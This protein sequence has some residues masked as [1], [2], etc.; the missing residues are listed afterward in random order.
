MLLWFIFQLVALAV[1]PTAFGVLLIVAACLGGW[2]NAARLS[3]NKDLERGHGG[4]HGGEHGLGDWPAKSISAVLAAM[5]ASSGLIDLRLA[6]VVVM[7]AALGSVAVSWQADRQLAKTLNRA[8]ELVLAWLVVGIPA[9]A[10][11]VLAQ[12]TVS[13]AVVL[14]CVVFIYETGT[15]IWHGV[16]VDPLKVLA[17]IFLSG[18]K[19]LRRKSRRSGSGR[20]R[21]ELHRLVGVFAGLTGACA[22]IFATTAVSL[23]PYVPEDSLRLMIIAVAT[24]L[25]A[26][27]LVVRYQSAHHR[28][29]EKH[30]GV[31]KQC[32][33]SL[34]RAP[35]TSRWPLRRLGVLFVIGPAWLWAIDLIRF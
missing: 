9:C 29:A 1:H 35:L 31:E 4:K 12:E 22:V 17:K 6:G 8:G 15:S 19:F 3:L 2:Q 7:G 25:T 18:T 33:A 13:G 24:L 26:Q 30:R 27:S 23:P 14:V 20:M 10:V 5:L 28:G 11:G 16:S 34:M 32:P 21:Q